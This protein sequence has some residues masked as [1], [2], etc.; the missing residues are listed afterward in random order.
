M[1]RHR[2]IRVTVDV[3]DGYGGSDSIDVTIN[4]TDV[5]D[6]VPVFTD[7]ASTTRSVAENTAT[8]HQR[9]YCRLLATDA[10]NDT[11][12]YTLG[13]TD[14]A[15]FS[16]VSTSGQLQTSGVLDYETTSSYSVTVDVSDGYGG[17]DSI[18]MSPSTLQI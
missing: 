11:L 7:G 1:K 16:I 17:S 5:V 9:R 15:S 8:G 13:G 2:P 12:T 10:D 3:N 14:A 4:V 18:V 6:H